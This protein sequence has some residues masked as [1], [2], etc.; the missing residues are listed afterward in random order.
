MKLT[1][2]CFVALFLI[3][4]LFT[5]PAVIQAQEWKGQIEIKNGVVYVYNPERPIY[6]KNKLPFIK[7][8]EVMSIG[9]WEGDERYI[10][11]SIVDLAYD[12][13]DNIYILDMK[14]HCVKVYDRQGQ[15]IRQIGKQG[16]GPCEFD[17]PISLGIT[18][19]DNIIV[20]DNRNRRIQ[21]INTDGTLE[22]TIQPPFS[23]ILKILVNRRDEIIAVRPLG[24]RLFKLVETRYSA[25]THFDL[26]GKEILAYGK[27]NIIEKGGYS[28]YSQHIVQLLPNDHLMAACY[29]P[30]KIK[31][32]NAS[33]KLVREIN[34]KDKI[35]AELK[36]IQKE[37]FRSKTL[38][39]RAYIKGLYVFPNGSF[40][41]KIIDLGKDWERKR[42]LPWGSSVEY[43]IRL[44]YFN[45]EGQFLASYAWD[46][47][48]YGGLFYIDKDGYAYTSTDSEGIP[49]LTKYEIDMEY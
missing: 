45:K 10:F 34:K 35:F 30:Y 46:K 6:Y 25:F 13:K 17:G 26:T 22:R 23:F 36:V 48:Q 11:G 28:E 14:N 37:G 2:F 8:K 7:L 27:G 44:D 43:D 1:Q 4:L 12:S 5:Q 19:N 15:Y 16:K 29:Y 3:I 40:L 42:K 20:N 32:Y 18:S 38:A 21:I 39:Y 49:K 41:I 9:V 24:E 47:E 31:E 33:G